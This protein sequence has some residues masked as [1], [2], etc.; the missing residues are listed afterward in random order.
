MVSPEEGWWALIAF[1]FDSSFARVVS[2]VLSMLGPRYYGNVELAVRERCVHVRARRD[3][4]SVVTVT[5]SA[6]VS[7]VT[8]EPDVD[9]VSVPATWLLRAVESCGQGGVFDLRIDKGRTTARVT[10]RKGKMHELVY[11][12]STCE[13]TNE[14][15]KPR[16]DRVEGF[17]GMLKFAYGA[18]NLAK[19]GMSPYDNVLVEI[20]SETVNSSA[21][22]VVA[23]NGVSLALV[24]WVADCFSW[25]SAKDSFVVPAELAKHLSKLR[26]DIGLGTKG[27]DVVMGVPGDEA[28]SVVRRHED[29]LPVERWRSVVRD[30]HK[31]SFR[32]PLRDLR[33]AIRTMS[34]S[35][36]VSLSVNCGHLVLRSV[37]GEILTTIEI[38]ADADVAHQ[39]VLLNPRELHRLLSSMGQVVEEYSALSTAGSGPWV[40]TATSP[41][42]CGE[43]MVHV[44]FG[45]EKDPI[46]MTCA[47]ADV[48]SMRVTCVLMPIAR[49]S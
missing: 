9:A 40:G 44:G 19:M 33:L 36:I 8:R 15:A 46:V 37:D 10:G 18:C 4:W 39:G 38:D 26:R 6:S 32:M 24:E 29:S 3:S 1:N 2:G 25:A 20:E 21:L 42:R 34:S 41:S 47:S 7:G 16:V 22:C 31:W 12:N 13:P 14:S 35:K 48:P 28:L 17:A 43:E 45:M 5:A 23:T 30:D 11:S 49:N 27:S